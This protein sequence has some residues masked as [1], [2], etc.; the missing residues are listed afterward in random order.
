MTRGGWSN[1][2]APPQETNFRHLFGL[3]SIRHTE[4]AYLGNGKSG[5]DRLPGDFQRAILPDVVG[6]P[7]AN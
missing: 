4:L 3:P 6:Q 7:N 2:T 5:L 1:R